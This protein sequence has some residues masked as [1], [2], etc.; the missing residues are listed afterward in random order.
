MAAKE[1]WVGLSSMYKCIDCGEYL[2]SLF[3]SYGEPST[4]EYPLFCPVHWRKGLV[5][6][7][8]LILRKAPEEEAAKLVKRLMDFIEAR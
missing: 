3:L 6:A 5:S 8:R 4:F 1:A 2:V 7:V